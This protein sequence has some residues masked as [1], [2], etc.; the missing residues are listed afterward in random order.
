M[1]LITRIKN[2]ISA[3]LYELLEQKEQKNPIGML[4]Q[5]LRQC[6][7]EVEKV[8]KLVERQYTLKQEFAREWSFAEQLAAKR[9]SQVEIASKAGEEQLQQFAMQE[10]LQYEERAVRL[11]EALLQA[12]H[13]LSELEQKYEEMKHKLKDMHIRRMELMGRENIARAHYR[14]N[15]VTDSGKYA[16]EAFSNFGEMEQYIER[17]EQKVN[18]DYNHSTIDTRIAQLEKELKKDDSST[19]L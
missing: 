9:K 8:R 2:T 7:Q 4:N 3:D 19:V 15:K 1:G 18:A 17:L 16:N 13:H 11:K 6:E 10:Q 14:M 12:E 5:H